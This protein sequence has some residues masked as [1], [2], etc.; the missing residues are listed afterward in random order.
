FKDADL[1][2]VPIRVTVGN[3]LAK[4]GAVEVRLRRTREERKVA[5]AA[6]VETV[7]SLRARDG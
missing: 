1:L 7:K 5:P 4:E 2:G 6:V 3:A